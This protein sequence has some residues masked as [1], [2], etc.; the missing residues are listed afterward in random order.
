MYVRCQP[1]LVIL[2]MSFV[3]RCTNYYDWHN[4]VCVCVRVCLCFRCKFKLY[5]RRFW[6]GLICFNAMSD[7]IKVTTAINTKFPFCIPLFLRCACVWKEQRKK[8]KNDTH[9][10]RLYPNR[11]KIEEKFDCIATI[12]SLFFRSLSTS[13]SAHTH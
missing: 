5:N 10:L 9:P 4:F 8:K 1:I 7:S 11:K 12:V 3:K 13:A 2:M 6:F